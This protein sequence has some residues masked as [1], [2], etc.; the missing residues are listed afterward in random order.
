M[1]KT[2]LR[3]L[4]KSAAKAAKA[5]KKKAKAKPT[6]N[7]NRSSAVT[8]VLQ[9]APTW[10]HG[11]TPRSIAERSL[12]TA[13]SG[14]YLVRDAPIQSSSELYV[15]SRGLVTHAFSLSIR[16]P[17]TTFLS[18]I[19]VQHYRI[20][21]CQRSEL[22]ELETGM[23]NRPQFPTVQSLIQFFNTSSPSRT[24]KVH[25]M[26]PCS[27]STTD[28]DDGNYVLLPTMQSGHEA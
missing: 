12:A 16:L 21:Q 8:V 7:A 25:L 15:G 22:F 13:K 17:Q 11:N 14:T 28:D 27:S 24:H 26:F 6:P 2:A 19:N 5:A 1:S 4:K 20:M 3:A 18:R 9:A 10:Y 23:L